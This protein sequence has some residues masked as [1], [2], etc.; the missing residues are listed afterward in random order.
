MLR[1]LSAMGIIKMLYPSCF[2]IEITP[3]RSACDSKLRVAAGMLIREYR[4]ESQG[5]AETVGNWEWRGYCARSREA[6]LGV[7][8]VR[9]V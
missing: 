3:K 2:R 5:N 1:S 8:G 9:E 4:G 6:S 7:R